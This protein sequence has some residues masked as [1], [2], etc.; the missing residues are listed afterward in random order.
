MPAGLPNGWCRPTDNEPSAPTNSMASNS[1]TLRPPHRN[2]RAVPERADSEVLPIIPG[3]TLIVI[4][5]KAGIH[6]GVDTG[7]RRYDKKK[8]KVG[9]TSRLDQETSVNGPASPARF[10]SLH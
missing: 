3:T 5:A 9:G 1:S 6:R 10:P 4:P 7:F 2:D 8:G